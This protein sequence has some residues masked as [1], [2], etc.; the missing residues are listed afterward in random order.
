MLSKYVVVSTLLVS[1]AS[2]VLADDPQLEVENEYAGLYASYVTNNSQGDNTGSLELAKQGSVLSPLSLESL[3]VKAEEEFVPAILASSDA[4]L[5]LNLVYGENQPRA[6]KDSGA[7]EV[8][9][10]VDKSG[11]VRDVG[12]LRSTNKDFEEVV[13]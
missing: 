11:V 8:T 2:C 12:V 10:I 1:V 6:S 4:R 7:V 5:H 3:P 13:L 9:Y